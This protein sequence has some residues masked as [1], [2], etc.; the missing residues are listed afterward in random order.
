ME[1][2]EPRRYTNGVGVRTPTRT[3]TSLDSGGVRGC[4]QS[5]ETTC[6]LR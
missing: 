1:P 2:V 6:N 3:Q 4:S 5:A